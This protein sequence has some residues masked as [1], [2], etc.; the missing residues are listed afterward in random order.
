VTHVVQVHAEN[1]EQSMFL[2]DFSPP[3]GPD[4]SIVEQVQALPADFIVAAYSPGR[5]VR[6]DSMA[7]AAKLSQC[8]KQVIFTLGC[9]DANKLLIQSHLLGAQVLGLKNVLILRGDDFSEKQLRNVKDVYDFTPTKLIASIK[10]MNQGMDYRGLQ[11]QTPTDFCVGATMDLGK[12][13]NEEV[14]LV[15]RKVLSGA[16]FFVA[17]PISGPKEIANFYE[18]YEKHA[19]KTFRC[20]IFWGLQ[21]LHPD[22]INFVDVPTK[23]RED[24]NRGR[25]GGDIALEQLQ[26]LVGAGIRNI[27]VIPPI[28]KG[29]RRDYDVA[30]RVIKLGKRM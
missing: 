10:D 20:P 14:S 15:H 27:Y 13:F 2:C 25:D 24:L 16:D 23:L 12:S 5:A 19:G 1:A 6:V 9:R 18:S 30:R 7:T 8:G 29:G 22:G 11:L 4:P 26:K 28:L 3:R 17:Q 21:I